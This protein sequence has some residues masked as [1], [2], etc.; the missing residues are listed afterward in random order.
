MPALGRVISLLIVGCVYPILAGIIGTA[1]ARADEE[2]EIRCLALTIYYEARGEPEAGQLAVGHVVMNRTRNANF[3]SSVCGVVQEGGEQ[4]NLCQFS[5]WCDGLSDRPKDRAALY[6]SLSIAEQ[7]YLGCRADPTRGA[8]WF[9]TTG[10]KPLWSKKFGRAQRI[11]DHL[12]Y[13]G[14][15]QDAQRINASVDGTTLDSARCGTREHHPT[16]R[17]VAAR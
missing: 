16:E 17:M 8:L 6:R 3:P 14:N 1:P 10:V 9:H 2:R 12:F 13:R 15:S 7:I 5:W 4:R 11:G